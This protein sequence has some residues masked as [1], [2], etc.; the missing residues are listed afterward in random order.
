MPRRF[1]VTAALPYANGKLHVGHVAGAYL[2]ADIF[3]RYLRSRGDEVAFICGSDD[4]GVPIQLSAEREGVS[5]PEVVDRYH[6]SQER[7]FRGL[8]IEFDIYG[9]T[10]SPRHIATSQAFFQ[11]VYDNGYLKKRNTSQLYDPQAGRFLPDRYVKGTCHHPGC[12]NP[13]AL[14]DQCEKCGRT[15]DPLKLGDPVSVLTG[16]RPEVRDTFHWYFELPR[17]GERLRAWIEGHPEWRSQVRQF[18]LGLLKEGLPERA[19]TRDLG[20]GVPVPLADPDAGGK[21]LYVWFDAPIGYVSFTAE[22]CERTTGR[23][24]DYQ[25]WW[26]DPETSIVHFIGEDNT[27][28]HALIWPAMLLAEGSFELPANVVANCFLNFQFP[29]KDEEKMSKSR[30]TAVWIED[31]LREFEPEALRYYLTSVAPENQRTA[32][33][34]DEFVGHTNDEL[35][36]TLGNFVHRTVTFAHR[37][38]EGK[39]PAAGDLDPQDRAHLESLRSLPGR[40]GAEIEGMHF[41][42]GLET[43]MAEARGANRYFDSKAPWQTRKTDLGSCGRAIHVCLWTARTL[44]TVMAPYLPF[45]GEKARKM[46]GLSAGEFVWTRAAD[47]LVAGSSLGAA[48]ILFKKIEKAPGEES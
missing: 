39:V 28:F 47:P 33:R 38:F 17:F 24:T 25:T 20:W 7:D 48:E 36:A 23:A 14:G 10:M 11:R 30:G 6:A 5:P 34:A 13:E 35:V 29:G 37:Y 45:A 9:K 40:V 21:V 26:K 43:I 8:G 42:A 1:L 27:V 12:G 22:W 46:L 3:V 15:I 4:H 2:P 16:A 32:Y 19:M 18:T 44:A 31:Y 41:K